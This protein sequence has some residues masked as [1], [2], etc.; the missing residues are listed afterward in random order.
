[1]RVKLAGL[2]SIGNSWLGA[3]GSKLTLHQANNAGRR[4]RYRT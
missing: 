2:I 4:V 1:M 3:L